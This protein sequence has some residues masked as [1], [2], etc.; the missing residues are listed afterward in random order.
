MKT[1]KKARAVVLI[2]AVLVALLF[3]SCAFLE[4]MTVS[5]DKP[6]SSKAYYYSPLQRGL[7][8]KWRNDRDSIVAIPVYYLDAQGNVTEP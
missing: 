5:P 7:Q 8:S 2:T 4:G 3:S 1:N 6:S